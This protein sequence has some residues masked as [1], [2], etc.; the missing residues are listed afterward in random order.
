[1]AIVVGLLL[2]S[3]V[4]GSIPWLDLGDRGRVGNRSSP[5]KS[6]VPS[7]SYLSLYPIH[8]WLQI[9]FAFLVYIL[10]RLL[11]WVY[12]CSVFFAI[13]ILL[14]CRVLASAAVF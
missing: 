12:I 7:L 9:A 5:L 6:Q 8:I 10:L 13:V 1:M 4:L 2:A 3:R 14:C 11:C